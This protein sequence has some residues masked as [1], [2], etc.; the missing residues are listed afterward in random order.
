MLT[1]LATTMPFDGETIGKKEYAVLCWHV[2]DEFANVV[3]LD[4]VVL[5]AGN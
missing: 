2:C 1:N 3:L 4:E 5:V